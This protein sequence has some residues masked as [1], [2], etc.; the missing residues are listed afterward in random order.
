MLRTH[1]KRHKQGL[2]IFAPCLVMMLRLDIYIQARGLEDDLA[3]Q[4]KE[5]SKYLT[6]LGDVY[7]KVSIIKIFP[8]PELLF[9]LLV[10]TTEN[11]IKQQTPFTMSITRSAA[12][13]KTNITRAAFAAKKM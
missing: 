8:M 7:S 2:W 12:Y 3:A 9:F 6:A 1:F 11:N 13:A 10:L 5:A 4:T